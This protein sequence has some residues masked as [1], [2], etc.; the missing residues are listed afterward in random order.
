VAEIGVDGG[1]GQDFVA[2][3]QDFDVHEAEASIATR[4]AATSA[5][6]T[7]PSG[8]RRGRPTRTA[9]RDVSGAQSRFPVLGALLLSIKCYMQSTYPY[10]ITVSASL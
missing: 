1:P 5:S 2:G 3:A 9:H 7:Q 8:W 10:V 4:P 6:E